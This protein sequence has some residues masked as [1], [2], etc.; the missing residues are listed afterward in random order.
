MILFLYLHPWNIIPFGENGEKWASF[1][2]KRANLYVFNDTY[3][4]HDDV[5]K[6]N[7]FR[8]TGPL[9]GEFTGEFLSQRPVSRGF[10][11]FFDLRLNERLSKQS[12]CR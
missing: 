7:I 12:R 3:F 1:D 6:W 8:V 5:I 11:A 9:C 10:G 2:Y 4:N